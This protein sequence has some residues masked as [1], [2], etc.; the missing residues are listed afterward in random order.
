MDATLINTFLLLVLLP[1]WLVVGLMDWWCH[2]VSRIETTVGPKESVLHLVLSAPAAVA[3]T[4]ALL[5]EINAAV[6]TI[7][8]VM[9]VAHELSTNLDVHLVITEEL[10]RCAQA[11]KP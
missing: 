6:I 9:F 4:P 1:A 5:L 8:I 10:W 7:L 3:I 11:R 2:R